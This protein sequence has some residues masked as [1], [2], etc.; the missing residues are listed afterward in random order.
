M[1]RADGTTPLVGR[2]DELAQIHEGLL[3][4]KEGRGST[5]FIAG[6][7]GIGKTRLAE[8]AMEFAAK[9]GFRI[10]RGWSLP[11]SYTPLMPIKEALRS[12]G[13]ESLFLGGR[14]PRIEQLYLLTNDGRL[15]A[16][17][18]RED[19]KLDS[20]IFSAM[21]RA[22]TDFIADAMTGMGV[23]EGVGLQTMGYGKHRIIIQFAK[24]SILATVLSTRENEFLLNDLRQLL[25]E[26]EARFGPQLRD[27]DGDRSKL[28]A[29]R[30]LLGRLIGSG[31][32]DGVEYGDQDPRVWQ[33]NLFENILL[34]LERKAAT[35]PILL[36]IDDIQWADPSTFALLH[37]LA[38]NIHDH[39]CLILAS[40]RSEEIAVSY[41]GRPHPCKDLIAR[42]GREE[43]LGQVNLERLPADVSKELIR[44]SLT[45]EMPARIESFL[46][47][48]AGGNPFYLLELIKMFLEEGLLVF[49]EGA[50]HLPRRLSDLRVPHRVQE[51]VA[52]RLAHL[53]PEMREVLDCA[54]VIGEE[55]DSRVV[56]EVL[57]L[58]RVRL[59]RRLTDIE[60]QYHLVRSEEAGWRF[61]HAKIREV[62]YAALPRELRREY[63]RLAGEAC[64]G[65][66]TDEEQDMVAFHLCSAQ[67]ERGLEHSLKA[68]ERAESDYANEEAARWYGLA[69]GYLG[70][71][72]RIEVLI[73]QGDARQRAGDLESAI[74][75]FAEA[76]ELAREPILRAT[77][78]RKR[79]VA[80]T[81]KGA[82]NSAIESFGSALGEL[83]DEE[84]VERGRIYAVKSYAE[85]L[86]D[87][88]EGLRSA[89][90]ALELLT[91]HDAPPKDL[92]PVY[93]NLGIFIS[94]EG[95]YEKT[96]EM[97]EKARDL[98]KQAGDMDYL[99]SL[100]LNSGVALIYMGELDRA[101]AILKEA[102]P[103]ILKY[104]F[105]T[106]LSYLAAN[107]SFAHR[108]KGEFDE[109]LKHIEKGMELSKRM[110]MDY[111][112]I[113]LMDNQ[114]MI[115]LERND[116]VSARSC[117]EGALRLADEKRLMGTKPPL[118]THLGMLA[119]AEG[120]AKEAKGHAEEA[121]TI[122]KEANMAWIEGCAL[123]A[124]GRTM[125]ALGD[126]GAARTHFEKILQMLEQEQLEL[127]R[128]RRDLAQVEWEL[129]NREEARRL[130]GEA[131]AFF[132]SKG[133][134]YE[135]ERTPKL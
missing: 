92:L 116:L 36:Y 132:E 35:E 114:G 108:E 125:M 121:L 68:A 106:Q 128:T 51:V 50:Y 81:R 60:R 78:W 104:G 8:Q 56:G 12:G 33:E 93:K 77:L 53:T 16:R 7:A 49:K 25:T 45:G 26:V 59:L 43:L 34:G 90:T 69:L 95:D 62:V 79:G 40:Y 123:R 115:H 37:Y 46:S 124:M 66:E 18:G 89:N 118:L 86:V 94:F 71:E 54:S 67:D 109:S 75:S 55:F 122:A 47:R 17:Q 96:L 15:I 3:G 32:Y 1:S 103:V 101:I 22:V 85:V 126:L 6:E 98:A 9:E 80:E 83:G 97:Y 84:H 58:S 73:K 100:L 52:R 44:T 99:A 61:D 135:V 4:A 5:L 48:E 13:L 42:M 129:G 30:E 120:D 88:K 11:E 20:D 105:Q 24:H 127:A 91:E 87:P 41:D 28:E 39:P 117:F 70:G 29:T 64:M 2:L 131:L 23:E 27:W 63:H 72:A 19:E 10:L 31:R 76:L 107:L 130:Q 112:P 57:D 111:I 133:L 102:E 119:L 134:D 38:R 113:D 14:A 65:G 82:S 21:L 110:G 74:E